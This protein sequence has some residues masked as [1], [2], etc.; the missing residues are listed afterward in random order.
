MQII[1]MRMENII[2]RFE[3]EKADGQT[4]WINKPKKWNDW[5]AW[6]TTQRKNTN[7][8]GNGIFHNLTLLLHTDDN[9]LS[10]GSN[11]DILAI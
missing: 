1:W 7:E 9:T 10:K 8:K 2:I 4:D 6:P 3:M 5:S 11:V